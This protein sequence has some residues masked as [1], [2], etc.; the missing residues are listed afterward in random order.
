MCEL[1]RSMISVDHRREKRRNT[2]TVVCVRSIPF[3]FPTTAKLNERLFFLFLFFFVLKM[4]VRVVDESSDE[5]EIVEI[6]L[7]G[8]AD[9][10]LSLSTLAAQFQ[11]V[12]ALKYR[13]PETSVWRG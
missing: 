10:F 7:E 12:T 4:F 9:G 1:Y 8:D 13:H 11:G 3:P 6:P 5:N 2:K